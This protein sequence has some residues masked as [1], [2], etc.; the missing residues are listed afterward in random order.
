MLVVHTPQSANFQYVSI[1]ACRT[2]EHT[3]VAHN[4][5][6][7]GRGLFVRRLTALGAQN[8]MP[9]KSPMPR[10]SPIT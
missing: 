8:S 7:S 10:T 1:A 2:D 9:I 4:V 6:D 3:P 5:A